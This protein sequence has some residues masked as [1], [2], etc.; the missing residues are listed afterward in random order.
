MPTRSTDARRS[1]GAD[2]ARGTQTFRVCS[3]TAP[4]AAAMIRGCRDELRLGRAAFLGVSGGGPVVLAVG[5]SCVGG[6]F[7]RSSR[8]ASQKCCRS[9]RAAGASTRSRVDAANRSRRPISS[10]SKAWSTGRLAD[11]SRAA[12]ALPCGAGERLPLRHRV[13]GR[14]RPVDGR[15]DPRRP[16]TRRPAPFGRCALVRDRR[17]ALRRLAHARIRHCS[18]T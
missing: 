4:T 10:A 15:A 16:C 9:R 8:A 17:S 14:G 11:V 6:G 1:S 5:P 12:Q 7:G 3:S 2:S 13:D 18:R